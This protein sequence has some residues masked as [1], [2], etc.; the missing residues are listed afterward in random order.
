MALLP[1]SLPG[2]WTLLRVA[3]SLPKGFSTRSLGKQLCVLNVEGLNSHV[4][5]GR[6]YINFLFAHNVLQV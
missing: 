1:S 6:G 2:P 5:G 3:S 4:D